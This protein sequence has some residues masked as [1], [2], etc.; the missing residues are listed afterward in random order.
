MILIQKSKE[1]II[2]KCY[3]TLSGMIPKLFNENSAKT[4]MIEKELKK[5][6]RTDREREV[7]RITTKLMSYQEKKTPEFVLSLL[8][9]LRIKNIP[10]NLRIYHSAINALARGK[11]IDSMNLVA[12]EM[13]E[14]GI[15]VNEELF[16]FII[17]AQKF[18][19]KPDI[20]FTHCKLKP[21]KRLLRGV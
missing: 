17:N 4:K 20:E 5:K 18:Q 3:V 11:K 1:K 19:T 21:K 8:D 15:K 16:A 6:V 2:K 13:I 12:K 14:S 7:K 10:K 9:D